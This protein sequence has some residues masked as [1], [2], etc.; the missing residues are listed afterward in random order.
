MI[1][2]WGEVSFAAT[3][4]LYIIALEVYIILWIKS[5]RL[6]FSLLRSLQCFTK[7]LGVIW[8]SRVASITAELI[9]KWSVLDRGHSGRTS[10]REG[11]NGLFLEWLIGYC[12][13]GGFLCVHAR[14]RTP[15]WWVGA[16]N[17]VL[18]CILIIWWVFW[19]GLNWFIGG[20]EGW[21]VWTLVCV[22][23]GQGKGGLLVPIPTQ[24]NVITAV[25]MHVNVENVA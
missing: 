2:I 3:T 22:V 23:C 25:S 13:S 15:V 7:T 6:T 20:R 17:N 14:L 9:F 24:L 21:A 5:S 11:S 8:N 18:E 4:R 10:S 19:A 12:D 16:Q 1:L